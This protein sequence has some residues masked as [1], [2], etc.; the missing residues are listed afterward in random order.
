MKRL[1]DSSLEKARV[2]AI[3]PPLTGRIESVCFCDW[4]SKKKR[5]S[6]APSI[7]EDIE[8]P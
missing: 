3:A 4:K 7:A 6:R 5:F 2:V 8:E 1:N